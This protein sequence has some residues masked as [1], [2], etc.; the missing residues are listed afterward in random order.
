MIQVIT[1]RVPGREKGTLH[2]MS[3]RVGDDEKPRTPLPASYGSNL[4]VKPGSGIPWSV[5][6]QVSPDRTV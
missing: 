6:C 1:P 5:V 4:T 3:E 2:E